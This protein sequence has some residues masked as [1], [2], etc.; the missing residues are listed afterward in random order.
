VSVEVRF[1][2]Y[3]AAQR[4]VVEQ[5]LEG[6]EVGVP[7]AV[8][9]D[10]EQDV[11]VF[12]ELAEV[13]GFG[14]CGREWLFDEDVFACAHSLGGEGGV[15]VRGCCEDYDVDVFVCEEVVG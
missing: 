8:L 11:V 3:D 13:L 10:C 2:F 15:G 1:E 9:V 5:R 14:R 12:G 4:A 6:Q 7:A